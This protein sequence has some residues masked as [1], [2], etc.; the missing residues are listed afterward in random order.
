MAKRFEKAKEYTKKY[1]NVLLP[2]KWCG[3]KDIN[4]TSERM[5]FN[6]NKNYY[7]VTCSTTNCDC[8]KFYTSVKDAVIA[9]NKK[10]TEKIIWKG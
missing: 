3:N 4:I 5:I 9:W 7:S 8:T 2:C 6:D 1:K 10:Q